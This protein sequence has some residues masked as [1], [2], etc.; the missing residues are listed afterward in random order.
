M[1]NKRNITRLLNLAIVFLI[2][3]SVYFFFKDWSNYFDFKNKQAELKKQKAAW[4]ILEG[5]IK[6]ELNCFNGKAGIVIKDLNKGWQIAI[7][8]DQPFPSASLVKI[9][10]MAA[11]F[12]AVNEGKLK[13]NEDLQLKKADKVSG[14]GNLK[15]LPSG[16]AFT[17]EKLIEM[18]ITESDNT[19]ANML[20]EQMGFDY[21]N[22]CFKKLKLRN[23]NISRKMMDFKGRKQGK[24]NFTTVSDLAFILEEIYNNRLVNKAYSQMCLEFLK[25]QNIRDRIP[26]KLPANII[27]AHKT[28]L[29]RGICHDAGII[30]APHLDI[31]IC[32]LTRHKGKTAKLAKAFIGELAFLAY[33][34][35]Q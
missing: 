11:C 29:E 6:K 8:Q 3:A 35:C 14:S 24:E 22:A 2:V 34:Y 26:S 1:M 28:G 17:I 21:L 20:I 33:R 4:K 19:A 13:L 25:K 7:N 23:T 12:W 9:P 27:V 16:S 5:N 10:I 30:F 32:V 15:N 18:M 31:L